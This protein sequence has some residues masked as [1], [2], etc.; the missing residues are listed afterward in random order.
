MCAAFYSDGTL[1]T[2]KYHP[3]DQGESNTYDHPEYAAN[4]NSMVVGWRQAFRQ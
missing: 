1:L 4:Q 3:T 2:R